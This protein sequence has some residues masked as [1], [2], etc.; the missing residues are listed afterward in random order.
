MYIY[1]LIY[2]LIYI[3]IHIY[4]YIYI[5][6]YQKNINV[7]LKCLRP[8]MRTLWPN[9][10]FAIFQFGRLLI[11]ILENIPAYQAR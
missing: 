11:K 8:H 5:Y 2:R 7:S 4:I 1:I 3:Y 6:I 10:N 9:V